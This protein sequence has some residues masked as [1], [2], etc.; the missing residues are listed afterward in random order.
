MLVVLAMPFMHEKL[1]RLHVCI[2]AVLF[3]FRLV[4]FSFDASLEAQKIY[5]EK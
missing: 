1:C 3:C 2:V 5:L 4:G